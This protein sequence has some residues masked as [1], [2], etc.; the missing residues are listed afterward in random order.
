MVEASS[1]QRAANAEDPPTD[2]A[3]DSWDEDDDCDEWGLPTKVWNAGTGADKGDSASASQNKTANLQRLQARVN[4]SP[5]PSGQSKMSHAAG[6]SII[7]SEKK[8]NAARNLGLTKESRATVEQVLDQRT[9]LVLSKFHKRGLFDEIH[10]CIS[11]GKEANVYY[12]SVNGGEKE[13]AVKVYKTSILVFKDRARYVEGEFRFRNGYCKGNPRKMVAQWAEKEMRNLKRLA[14]AGILCPEVVEVRQNVLVM[15]FIGCDGAAAPRLKDVEDL[16]TEEWFALYRECALK[17][18]ALMKK[19]HLVHGDL[20]EYNILY[21]EGQL[22]I[23]DVSQSVECDH[24]QALDFLKRDCVNVN[25]FFRKKMDRPTVPVKELFD[26]I[27]AKHL[28]LPA[29]AEEGADPDEATIDML[30]KEANENPQDEDAELEEEVFVRTWIPSQ[31]NQMADRAEIERELDR[32]A[33]GE[34]VLYERL[35]ASPRGQAEDDDEE[36]DD[37]EQEEEEEIIEEEPEEEEGKKEKKKGKKAEKAGKT[38]TPKVKS[39]DADAKAGVEGE[40]GAAEDEDSDGGSDEDTESDGETEGQ[41]KVS[42]RD[43]RIPEGM[44][45]AEWKALVKE[46]R[47]EKRKDKIPKALKKKYRKQAARGR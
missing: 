14:S 47:R 23:I 25:N 30:L 34:E 32:R 33:R 27:V 46:E 8:A 28:P 40:D 3:E 41:S 43:G 36:N 42:T 20:S 19:C 22:C 45:K 11:T 21:F 39:A 24:P 37:E 17:M 15:D 10:G 2:D 29:E 5:L 44:T 7:N 35:L 26:Y 1:L 38:G 9:M 31:L 12:A 6:N 18:R 13:R 4:F 16:D